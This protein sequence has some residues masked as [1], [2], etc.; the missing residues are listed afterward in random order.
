MPSLLDRLFANNLADL[1]GLELKGTIP[2]KE[3][4]ANELITSYMNAFFTDASPANKSSEANADYIK[5]LK[6][7]KPGVF[8]ISFEA[9]KAVVHFELKR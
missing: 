6:Q 4:L 2:I 9:G 1:E 8:D 3:E 5:L 7:L